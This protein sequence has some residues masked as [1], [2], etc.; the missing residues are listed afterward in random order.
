MNEIISLLQGLVP[1]EL[2]KIRTEINRLL[3]P[4]IIIPDGYISTTNFYRKY[5]DK[6]ISEIQLKMDPNDPIKKYQFNWYVREDLSK[7]L[8]T[9]KQGTIP[10]NIDIVVCNRAYFINETNENIEILKKIIE[11]ITIPRVRKLFNKP[12]KR[13]KWT[14][15]T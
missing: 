11:E 8:A 14:K 7:F 1:E 3:T 10:I 15:H 2:I 13:K 5:V 4:P 6:L 12:R 9:S